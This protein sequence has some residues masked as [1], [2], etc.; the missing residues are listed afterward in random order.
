MCRASFSKSSI[1]VLGL[2]SIF[3]TANI[4]RAQ[5]LSGDDLRQLGRQQ[6]S[7][8]KLIAAERSFRLALS[9][10]ESNDT[11]AADSC[12]P[13]ESHPLR[14]CNDRIVV[15]LGDFSALLN[16]QGR[17]SESEQLVKRALDM[18]KKQSS[19]NQTS[20]PILQGNLATIYQLTGR[21]KL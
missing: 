11:G 9:R 18:L 16:S 17:Y 19:L 14:T 10:F 6:F 5:D 20:T 12:F 8:G 21:F 1:L 3:V 7:E 4:A 15:T 2:T 13:P